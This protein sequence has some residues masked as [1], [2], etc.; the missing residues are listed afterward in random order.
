MHDQVIKAGWSEATRTMSNMSDQVCDTVSPYFCDCNQFAVL[1]QC[2]HSCVRS[3]GC[4]LVHGLLT[5]AVAWHAPAC[6]HYLFRVRSM[7]GS[8]AHPSVRWSR[9]A[10]PRRQSD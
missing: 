9:C 2:W 5:P 4:G 8:V 6:A 10:L 3:C 1:I 7:T